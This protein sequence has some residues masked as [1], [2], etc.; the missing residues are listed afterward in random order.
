MSCLS[1]KSC[2]SYLCCRKNG[3]TNQW[4]DL[5]DNNLLHN[6]VSGY[7]IQEI[8]TIMNKNVGLLEFKVMDMM[9]IYPGY[10]Q[11]YRNGPGT[12]YCN[13]LA[14]IKKQTEYTEL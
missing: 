10:E 4:T 5:D 3:Y 12:N 1:I 2:F 9:A 11:A 7:N 14:F 6:I 8:S 13:F